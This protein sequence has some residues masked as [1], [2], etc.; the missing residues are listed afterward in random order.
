MKTVLAVRFELRNPDGTR[1]AFTSPFI[2]EDP[3]R[4]LSAG[5]IA[6]WCG[7][8]GVDPSTLGLDDTWKQ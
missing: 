4:P 5:T 8:L 3:N 6:S 1:A 2:V 7:T